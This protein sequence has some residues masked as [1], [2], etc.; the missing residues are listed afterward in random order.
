MSTGIGDYKQLHY[1]SRDGDLAMVRYFLRDHDLN[2]L[3]PEV[4]TAP[5]HESIRNRH[6]IVSRFLLQHGANPNLREGY[7]NVTPVKIAR[8]NKDK[9]ALALLE[10]FGADVNHGFLRSMGES[11]LDYLAGKIRF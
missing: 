10:E 3:H 1:A 11:I 5:L 9:K 7:S 8:A 2:F 6:L 4:F